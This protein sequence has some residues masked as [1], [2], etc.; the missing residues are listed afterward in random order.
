M[1]APAGPLAD[2][3]ALMDRLYRGQRHIY[4]ATRRYFLF[5]RDELIRALDC[6]AGDSVL[7]IACGTGRN[8]VLI[9]RRWPGITLFGLDIS[10]E[11]LKSARARLGDRAFLAEGDATLPCAPALLGR[12][13][14]DRVVISYALSMIPD[15]EA[16][17]REALCVVAPGGEL[18]VVD[19]G[20]LDGLP[21]PL[22]AML[23][24]WLRHFHVEPRAGLTAFANQEAAALG[25][26][27]ESR[28]GPMGYFQRHVIRKVVDAP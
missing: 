21:G 14:F 3:A 27:I 20:D 8:L 2:H 23:G 22:T 17:F 19:F 16:A 13:G 7:E 11:M 15:W 24:A 26:A 25:F 28:S 4:D 5:G 9:G 10:S 18:H 12:S 1:T 6:K